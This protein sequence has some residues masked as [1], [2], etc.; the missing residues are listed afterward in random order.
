MKFGWPSLKVPMVPGLIEILA[1]GVEALMR[2]S[3][4]AYDDLAKVTL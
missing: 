1:T 2:K 3:V 4:E